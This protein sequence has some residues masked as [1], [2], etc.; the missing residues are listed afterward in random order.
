MRLGADRA[1]WIRFRGNAYD[2]EEERGKSSE[3]RDQSGWTVAESELRRKGLQKPT[4]SAKEFPKVSALSNPRGSLWRRGRK[5]QRVT[6]D[7]QIYIAA[8][9]RHLTSLAFEQC[10]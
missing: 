10:S 9:P 3:Y 2:T 7:H 8:L 5:M 4:K 6:V 1:T